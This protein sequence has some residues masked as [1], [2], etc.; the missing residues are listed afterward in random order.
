VEYFDVIDCQSHFESL[1]KIVVI[2]HYFDLHC[3]STEIADVTELHFI[4]KS[5]SLLQNEHNIFSILCQ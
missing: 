2:V 4:S 5:L 1:S 3:S